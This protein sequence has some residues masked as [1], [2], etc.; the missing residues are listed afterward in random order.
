MAGWTDYFAGMGNSAASDQIY[1]A[2]Q[3][4]SAAGLGIGD[5]VP[6]TES[7]SHRPSDAAPASAVRFGKNSRSGVYSILTQ[8]MGEQ[9]RISRYI[10]RLVPDPDDAADVLQEVT[11][12]VLTHAPDFDDP[13]RF[14]AWCRGLA[15]HAASRWQRRYSRQRRAEQ[16]AGFD[17]LSSDSS[18]TRDPEQSLRDQQTVARCLRHLDKKT[19][20]LLFT[21]Y[22]LEATA[23]EIAQSESQSPESIRMRLMR[24]RA[25]MRSTVS[26]SLR[27]PRATSDC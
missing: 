7:A 4:G 10:R 20:E 27:D 5:A 26:S 17:C 13:E 6:A 19:Q 15:R 22:V 21:R 24:V 1:D 3:A 16:E 12:E 8:F 25:S 14:A 23:V 18:Y 9:R 2:S 11:V